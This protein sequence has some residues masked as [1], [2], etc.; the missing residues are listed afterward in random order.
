VTTLKKAMESSGDFSTIVVTACL[1]VNGWDHNLQTDYEIQRT[2]INRGSK[3]CG[4][5]ARTLGSAWAPACRTT[6]K[7]L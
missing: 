7:R 1:L 6:R 2:S 5:S 4:N 3:F